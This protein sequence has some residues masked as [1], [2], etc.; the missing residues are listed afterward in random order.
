MHGQKNIKFSTAVQHTPTLSSVKYGTT[1]YLTS[2]DS[3][4][5]IYTNGLSIS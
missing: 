3:I 5:N 4:E 1:P 2:T